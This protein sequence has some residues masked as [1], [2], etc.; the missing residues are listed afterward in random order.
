MVI[1]SESSSELVE[2]INGRAAEVGVQVRMHAADLDGPRQVGI[3]ADEP[4]VSASVFKVPVSVELARQ[5][6]AGE[7]GLGERITVPPGPPEPRSYGLAT[8][9]HDATMSWFD[10]A[11]LMIGVSDNVATDL[12][13]GKV[14][15]PAVA[16]SLRRPGLPH[17]AVPQNCAELIRV[18]GEDLAHGGDPG[19]GHGDEERA[20]AGLSPAQL[21]RLRVLVPE[22]T[23]RTTAAESTR[24][25]GLIW[26][27]EAAPPAACA[28]VR[29]WL[30][31]QGAAPA[32]LR[33][34]GR[35]RQG[36][37]QDGNPAL[38]AQ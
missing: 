29:R 11:V 4:V 12:I 9:R 17:T 16:E 26:R 5:G 21:A 33:L 27:D 14:G 15:K 22:R 10:L 7:L 6:A 28:D 25:L 31:F 23:C 3:G 24:L 30:E 18:L 20:M 32:A 34:P 13:L 35:R 36:Q 19:T 38:R 2:T 37:R 8:F 1:E